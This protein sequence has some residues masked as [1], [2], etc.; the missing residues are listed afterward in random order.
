ME[1][2]FSEMKMRDIVDLL[3]ST[4]EPVP[5]AISTTA[6]NSIMGSALIR[7]ACQVEAKKVNKSGENKLNEVN[8]EMKKLEKNLYQLANAD[9]MAWNEDD[10]EKRK[11]MLLNVPLQLAHKL[12]DGIKS[13]NSISSLIQ[14]Q[15][16]SD[17]TSG[18]EILK[19]GAKI[20]CNIYKDNVEYFQ[21]D[22]D[23]LNLLEQKYRICD[24]SHS[25]L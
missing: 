2:D 9:C 4:K 5:A 14:G 21:V 18:R 8:K 6:L 17:Y 11:R 13:V 16:K 10:S 1:Y 15:I 12:L 19:T 7:L 22:D 23:K 3:A 20:T 24:N 25:N